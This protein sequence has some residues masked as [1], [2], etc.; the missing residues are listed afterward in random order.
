MKYEKIK[1][2]WINGGEKSELPF[3]YAFELTESKVRLSFQTENDRDWY[4]NMVT[5]RHGGNIVAEKR[6]LPTKKGE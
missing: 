1:T 6:T 5:G 4:L 2:E 3:I